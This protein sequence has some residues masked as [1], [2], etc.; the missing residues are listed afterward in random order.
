MIVTQKAQEAAVASGEL[1]ASSLAQRNLSLVT[2]KENLLKVEAELMAANERDLAEARV[3]LAKGEISPS[4]FSRLELSQKKFRAILDGLEVVASLSEPL[5]VRLLSRQLDSDLLLEKVSCPIGVLAIIFEARPDALPQIAAL[6][7]KSGNAVL[8]KGGSEARNTNEV[9]FTCLVGA[10][11]AAGLPVKCAQLLVER[12]DVEALLKLDQYVDL[13][14]PR[15]SGQLVSYIRQNTKIPVL[16][17]AEGVCHA[18]VDAS[19]DSEMAGKLLL[20]AK[21][22]YPAAC[23][24]IETVLFDQALPMKARL[25]LL[26]SLSQAG[27]K[28]NVLASD[29]IYAALVV[30]NSADILPL[31][32]SDFAREY[33]ELAISVRSV[34]GVRGAIEH[35]KKYSSGHTEMVISRSREV[36]EQFFRAVNSAGIYWNASTRFADGYRYGFGAEVGISTSKLAPRGPVG[37]EGLLSFKYRL[38]GQGQ[39]VQDYLGGSRSFNHKDLA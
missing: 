14:I 3:M 15:G 26:D 13:I 24:S 33:G 30:A 8:L 16:G 21:T 36:Y 31:E 38:L 20:D 35:V 7:I 28:L 17:H 25:E 19:C 29:P 27:V 23:N 32:E 22:N 12:S 34:D 1:G 39:I 9:L 2:F 6:A 10:L 5:G 4:L 11:E 37:I 18:Y